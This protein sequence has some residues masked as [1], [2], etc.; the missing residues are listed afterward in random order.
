MGRGW[1]S[2]ADFLGRWIIPLILLVSLIGVAF[3][4][5]ELSREMAAQRGIDAHTQRVT[6]MLTRGSVGIGPYAR[7]RTMVDFTVG[8]RQITTGVHGIPADVDSGAPVCLEVDSERPMQARRCGT[9]GGLDDARRELLIA[10]ATVAGAGAL[11]GLYLWRRRIERYRSQ[12][13]LAV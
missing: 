11:W 3:G 1:W 6:G 8:G 5:Y 9:R 2:I 4:A 7:E 12:H 13:P 10:G